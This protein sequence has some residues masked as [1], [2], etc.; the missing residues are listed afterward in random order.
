MRKAGLDESPVGINIAGR[1]SNN[2][3]YADDTT[4]MAESEEELKSLLMRV[5][6]ESAKVGL[7]LNIK[8]IKIMASSPITSWQIDGEEMELVTDFIFLGS[9]ITTDGD[10]SQEIKRRLLLG[11]KTLANLDSV[12]KSR[13][14]TLPTKVH[15]VKAMVF[16]V[17]MYGCESWTIRKAERQR[18]EAFELRCW[19]RLLRVP[20]TARPDTE[21]ET[22]ILWPPNEKEGLPGEEPNAGNNRWQKKKG[23]AEDE[24]WCSSLFPGRGSQC[25]SADSLRGPVASMTKHRSAQ[26]AV[27]F[28]PKWYL[29][30]SLHLQPFGLQGW[31]EL[32]WSNGNS[33]RNNM[34]VTEQIS[35][36][37]VTTPY[38][39]HFTKT[40]K[41]FKPGMSYELMVYVTNPDGSPAPLIPV[42]AELVD[43]TESGSATT[44]SDGTARIILNI[45]QDIEELRINVKTNHALLP[46]K[47]Q[48]RASIVATAYETQ[49]GSGNYLHIERITTGQVK[50][51]DVLHVRFIM[52]N[53][54]VQTQ[55]FTY[56]CKT[57]YI[58]KVGYTS[59]LK[60]PRIAITRI[61]V[62]FY[63][64]TLLI[65]LKTL[66]Q[67]FFTRGNDPHIL[68]K[69]KV[70]KAGRLPRA[71]GQN[72]ASLPLHITLELIPSFW[73]V[74]YYQVGNREIVADSLWVDVK[75]SCMGTKQ[76]LPHTP[77]WINT[78]REKDLEAHPSH[79]NPVSCSLPHTYYFSKKRLATQ[80]EAV[81]NIY[82][83]TAV[84][85]TILPHKPG[86]DKLLQC[87][88]NAMDK[89]RR[90][91]PCSICGA[92]ASSDSGH[93]NETPKGEKF[94]QMC[95][96]APQSRQPTSSPCSYPP[97]YNPTLLFLLFPI[98]PRQQLPGIMSSTPGSIHQ[99]WTALLHMQLQILG[100]PPHH[101]QIWATAFCTAEQVQC[102]A[103]VL[104]ITTQLPPDR[105]HK[106]AVLQVQ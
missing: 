18:I 78:Q 5:K 32:G 91:S 22:Q 82:L 74:A 65:Y 68:S 3:R 23:T 41:Y 52:N 85:N 12:L 27:T 84:T 20:W 105:V 8:K 101:W 87:T 67:N 45:P 98:H 92:I 25:L 7:K 38:E 39:I 16:P 34:V 4:L 40:S 97:P 81:N 1:N 26:N 95:Q 69:G 35:I 51:G 10:C 2:L 76:V 62:V 9:Q 88:V 96:T 13:D 54:D 31:R 29:F 28:P 73:I 80:A 83:E 94:D 57:K 21:D 56:I 86:K 106:H 47:R 72:M 30:I 103:H 53:Q 66:Y 104:G 60:I 37:I 36:A 75:D 42:T 46:K 58:W 44:Q 102:G 6:E 19:R 77:S 89:R 55:Y 43:I 14:I 61:L 17:A 11:R 70:I 33:P 99:Y 71:S 24:G 90:R 59:F 79:A 49:E 50:A 63:L 93:I 48:A 15:I 64:I 100:I